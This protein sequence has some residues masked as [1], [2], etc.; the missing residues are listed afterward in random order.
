M[1][2]DLFKE[3]DDSGNVKEF[4]GKVAKVFEEEDKRK[5]KV[6]HVSY[7]DGDEEGLYENEFVEGM[8]RY[9]VREA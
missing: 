1:C 4:V 5:R 8:I 9:Q 2:L 3:E 7:D 6:W